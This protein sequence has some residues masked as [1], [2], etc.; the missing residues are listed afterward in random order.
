MPLHLSADDYAGHTLTP[1]ASAVPPGTGFRRRAVGLSAAVGGLLV[2]AGFATT[3]W[4]TGEGTLAYLDSL[5]VDPLRSQ[6]AAVLLFFGYMGITPTLLT[7]A[8]M[9][10]RRGRVLGTLALVLSWIGTLALPGLLVTD[11]Y[12]LS[13]RQHLAPDVAVRVSEGA[14]NLPLAAFLGGP[15]I[16]LVFLG[17]ALGAVAGW[18]A[19]FLHWSLGLTIVASVGLTMV[20]ALR[21]SAVA[22]IVGGALL[23][24]YLLVVGVRALR[25][26][27]REWLTGARECG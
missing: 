20:P 8:A 18:R 26:S 16:M 5:T 21:Y 7:L 27:D 12:D 13:I 25:M 9:T 1:P 24:L 6:V 4:E 23:G 10:R 14:Q 3:V 15:T 22:S 19:G 11:F 2:A 17:L